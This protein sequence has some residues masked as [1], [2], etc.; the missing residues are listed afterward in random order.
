[1]RYT[2]LLLAGLGLFAVMATTAQGEGATQ[3]APS[4]ANTERTEGVVVGAS[5]AHPASWA[6]ERERYVSGGTFG[7]TLWRPE[8]DASDDY[9]G[10]S[11]GCV[12]CGGEITF[13]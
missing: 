6:V 12:G 13:L 4:A 5:I 3:P 1:M 10:M 11:G 8:P 2:R 9:G 7:F